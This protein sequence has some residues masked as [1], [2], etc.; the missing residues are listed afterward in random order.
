MKI[1]II[2]DDYQIIEALSFLFKVGW[3]DVEIIS[4]ESGEEGLNMITTASPEVNILDLGLPDINGFTILKNIR[5]FSNIPIIILTVSGEENNIIKGLEMGADEFI[6]K[7]FK[8]LELIARIKKAL[9]NRNL[10]YEQ[11]ALDYGW[12]KVNLAT[13]I[14]IINNKTIQLTGTE[15]LILH[16]LAI[17]VGKTLT[18]RQIA[19]RIWG[20]NYLDSN[21][22]IRVYI[23]RL[24]KKI[25]KDANHPQFIL[26]CPGMGY[27]LSK[28]N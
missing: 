13:R 21:K 8:S 28:A 6:T 16:Y 17:N 12:L 26:T 22:A 18:N 25:E 3:A 2:E 4:A 5:L 19:E 23:R 7:P 14:V 9:K 1:L 27:M 24:R 10:F 15:L 11:P 20:S